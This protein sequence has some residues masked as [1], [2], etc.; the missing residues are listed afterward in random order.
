MTGQTRLLPAAVGPMHADFAAVNVNFWVTP[1]EANLD[2]AGGGLM[3]WDKEASLDWDFATYNNDQAAI[4]RFLDE[5]GAR[6]I[7]VPHRQ[8]R[9]VIFNSDPL[10]A[11]APLTFRD[12]Y[13]NRRDQHHHALRPPRQLIPHLRAGWRPHRAWDSAPIPP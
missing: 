3:A 4:R 1:D 10:H 13:E 8:N 11:T 12:G 7:N 5:T 9:V 2:P 6:A